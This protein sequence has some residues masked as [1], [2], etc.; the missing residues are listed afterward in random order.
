MINVDYSPLAGD[1]SD[2]WT[3][4]AGCLGSE[5]KMQNPS[6]GL[7]GLEYLED[8]EGWVTGEAFDASQFSL[9]EFVRLNLGLALDC[10]LWSHST[11]LHTR[12]SLYRYPPQPQ[13]APCLSVRFGTLL[14]R[15]LFPN[16]AQLKAE[17]EPKAALT[18]ICQSLANA[19]QATAF[20]VYKDDEE[21]LKPIDPEQFARRLLSWPKQSA[22][23]EGLMR[24][25][26]TPPKERVGD[27][28]GISRKFLSRQALEAVWGVRPTIHET[29]SGFV[30]LDLL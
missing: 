20:I 21:H 29:T 24:E 26:E 30:I 12:V 25:L 27:Y 10:S 19:T 3:R 1:M 9:D 17:E 6:D 11:E 4:V 28:N 5:F 16:V 7:A 8:E 13:G 14:D 18:R 23:A 2:L 22:G 15:Q